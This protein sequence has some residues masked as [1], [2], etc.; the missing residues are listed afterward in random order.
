ML[1]VMRL[2]Y[3]L[4]YSLVCTKT[5]SSPVGN[6]A[7]HTFSTRANQLQSYDELLIMPVYQVQTQLKS[8]DLHELFVSAVEKDSFT[9]TM[10]FQP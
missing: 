5:V 10:Q 9:L 4:H 1:T 3:V 7:L 8:H 6:A 2:V